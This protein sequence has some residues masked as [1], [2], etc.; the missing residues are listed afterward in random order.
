ML[1]RGVFEASVRLFC[2][3]DLTVIRYAIKSGPVATAQMSSLGAGLRRLKFAIPVGVGLFKST[4]KCDVKL[5]QL[6]RPLRRRGLR[7]GNLHDVAAILFFR[8]KLSVL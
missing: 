1:A 6:G 4:F 5:T 3:Y 2:Q 8:P 7:R